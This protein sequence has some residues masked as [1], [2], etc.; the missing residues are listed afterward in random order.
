MCPLSP[1]DTSPRTSGAKDNKNTRQFCISVV[2]VRAL[3]NKIVALCESLISKNVD[4]CCITETWLHSEDTAVNAE[5]LRYGY[6]IVHEPRK[7]GNGGGVG[8]VSKM[9][10]QIRVLQSKAYNFFELIQAYACMKAKK[11]C[12]S[13]IYRTG[14]LSAGDRGLFLDEYESFLCS[15]DGDNTEDVICGDF[16]IH[17]NDKNNG[18]AKDFLDLN[19]SMNF[20][21]NVNVCTHNSGNTLDL[22]LTRHTYEPINVVVYN[23]QNDKVLSD[24]FMISAFF[25][26]CP[27]KPKTK[28]TVTYRKLSAINSSEF[29]DDLNGLL[30]TARGKGDQDMNVKLSQLFSCINSVIDSHAP[31]I[32]K[33]K[34]LSTKLFTN[35]EIDLARRIKRQKER[36]F[37]KS[38]L[39]VD[40][41]AFEASYKNLVKI[42][43]VGQCQFFDKKFEEANGNPKAVFGIV[44]RLLHKNQL[45]IL[46]DSQNNGTLANEFAA[47]FTEKIA[48]I[49]QDIG[50]E[51]DCDFVDCQQPNTNPNI[52]SF[53]RFE[54]ITKEYLAE[55]IRKTNK[56]YSSV[57]N[58]PS[59]LLNDI[60]ACSIDE[61]LEIINES[62]QTGTF[63]EGLKTSHITPVIKDEKKDRNTYA[64]F[65]PINDLSC[66]SKLTE[67]CGLD[68]LQ[69]HLEKKTI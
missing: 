20:A 45:K 46:P 2:N 68:Q 32:T 37:R 61:I 51:I 59:S 3:R 22:L 41:R 6:N 39:E 27:T 56:K 21:Q 24:H 42:V 66:V 17:V 10:I 8:I 28:T 47:F 64:N 48:R 69:T 16:N 60:L 50:P 4:I 1:F 12:L 15:L 35:P 25:P 23:H 38:G 65:R 29:C 14:Q 63:P 62:L 36:K 40:K 54:I 33:T 53:C 9:D 49:V 34:M 67:K 7:I 19:E 58:F 55:L 30:M 52:T 11:I 43:R 31:I 5:F 44:N 57:D 26:P 13:V 18:L